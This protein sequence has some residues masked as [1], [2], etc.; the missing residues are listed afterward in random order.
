MGSGGLIRQ[1][2]DDV[3]DTGITNLE[4][5]QEEVTH[6]ALFGSHHVLPCLGVLSA[7]PVTP[8]GLEARVMG[9]KGCLRNGLKASTNLLCLSDAQS[10]QLRNQL[11]QNRVGMKYMALPKMPAGG[12]T[13]GT[14]SLQPG[15]TQAWGKQ[16]SRVEGGKGEPG[17]EYLLGRSISRHRC[18]RF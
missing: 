18:G 10:Q 11:L 6:R 17:N 12:D 2:Q 7:V 15:D 1:P 9:I 8:P 3:P 4:L 13:V 5:F 16:G 14:S